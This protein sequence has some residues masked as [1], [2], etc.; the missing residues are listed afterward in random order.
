MKK[1]N[2]I[3]MIFSAIVFLAFA[4]GIVFVGYWVLLTSGDVPG[5]LSSI[6]ASI[7]NVRYSGIEIE[8]AQKVSY[9]TMKYGY[10]DDLQLAQMNAMDQY[11]ENERMEEIRAI[12][13]LTAMSNLTN[14]KIAYELALA[15]QA[16]RDKEAAEAK[17]LA[18]A[19]RQAKIDTLAMQLREEHEGAEALYGGLTTTDGG[20]YVPGDDSDTGSG[21]T[22]SNGGAKGMP[23]YATTHGKSLGTYL[24]TAYCTCRVCCGIY[25]GHNRTASGTIPTSNRTLA[26][27]TNLISFGTKLVIRGQVYVAEDRGGAV[28]GK[29][30]DMF[31][32]THKEALN[33]GKQYYEVFLYN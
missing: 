7:S 28:K 4:A 18:D 32:Y 16:Q 3:K 2:Q 31:F 17:A 15:E 1:K 23:V 26:V 10:M 14:D 27:D 20:T 33:W 25:S 30:I 19:A 8:D 21:D 6:S 29:H 24:I 12:N 11:Y 13:N 22:A 9:N 5:K